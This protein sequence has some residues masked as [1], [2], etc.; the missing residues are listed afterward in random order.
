MAL[1]T[2]SGLSVT[3]EN[4]KAAIDRLNARYGDMDAIIQAHVNALY[5]DKLI[6]VPSNDNGKYIEKLWQFYDEVNNHVQGLKAQGI[7]G[8][9]V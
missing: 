5:D 6:V 2:V 3:A 1:R 9:Q 4:Y 8:P 7:E